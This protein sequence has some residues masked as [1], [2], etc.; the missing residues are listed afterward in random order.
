MPDVALARLQ[1]DE[2]RFYL[3][4]GL[5]VALVVFIVVGIT[6]R[7][8]H[9]GLVAGFAAIL[10]GLAEQPGSLRERTYDVTLFAVL[11]LVPMI[12]AALIG[13]APP[14]LLALLFASTAAFTWMSGYGK[15]AAHVGWVLTVWTTL[16]MGFRTWETTPQSY[17]GYACGCLMVV[18][19]VVVPA[20]LRGTD[21]ASAA[22]PTRLIA[23]RD[24]P[25]SQLLSFALIKATAITLAGLIG[26]KYFRL[27]EFWVALTAILMMPPAIKIHWDR[28]WHRALGTIL[29]AAVGYGLV[30]SKGAN[31]TV[32]QAIEIAAAFMLITTI[33]QKPYGLFVFFITIFV[34][35]QLGLQGID[36][37]REGGLERI[38]ATIAGIAIAVAASA[39][40]VPVSRRQG[41]HPKPVEP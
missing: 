25:S 10:A 14:G 31:E 3:E 16:S 21:L 26:Q 23:V 22:N 33:K 11:G 41:K 12:I 17:F 24:R 36:V 38:Q 7:M 19:A 1:T 4:E 8:E 34:V 37:A 27:N 18:F 15:R 40:L 6:A 9:A 29:G 13:G 35:A 20:I 28:I 30:W 5:K 39:V 2:R 32:L